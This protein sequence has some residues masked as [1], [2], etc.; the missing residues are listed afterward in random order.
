MWSD[1]EVQ[2]HQTGSAPR[3][4]PAVRTAPAQRPDVVARASTA[5]R[6]LSP[7]DVLHLQRTAGNAA[8]TRALRPHAPVD[9]QRL[10]PEEA[11]ARIQAIIRARRVREQVRVRQEAPGIV[12]VR[13]RNTRPAALGN[14][15]GTPLDA[16][17]QPLL[18]DSEYNHLRVRGGATQ[19][20]VLGPG[21]GQPPERAA[22][23]AQGLPPGAA[24]INGGFFAHTPT[25]R[26]EENW[27]PQPIPD[28]YDAYEK[29][30]TKHDQLAPVGPGGRGR[31]VGPT[32]H[33]ADHLPIPSEYVGHYGQV[34]VGGQVG[35]SS[36]PLL[37]DNDVP[38]HL[39]G[40]ERFQYRIPGDEGRLE[41]NPRNNEVGALTHSGERNARAAISTQG[42]DVLMHTVTSAAMAPGAG[43][44][45]AQWQQMT[46]SAAGHG[47]AAPLTTLNLDG[48]GSVYMGV[49]Q[50]GAA[51]R[52]VAKG[53]RP[54]EPVERPV[55]NIIA[56][57]PQLP[58]PPAPAPADAPGLDDRQ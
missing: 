27:V 29:A 40:D 46:G 54:T 33:R 30:S 44:T 10:T 9:V 11:L 17:R 25:I 8:A 53:Q 26:S 14:I 37:T 12:G 47:P 22:A 45:M 13:V 39:P 49:T 42:E 34:N 31:P 6:L 28:V 41:E 36:G 23:L 19:G 20:A 21:P 32:S 15:A 2:Q 48:G 50:P 18:G 4:T 24:I 7:A 35:L 43:V 52:V 3:G 55:A 57:L 51:P 58:A 38:R 56:S 1:R 5:P 16:I